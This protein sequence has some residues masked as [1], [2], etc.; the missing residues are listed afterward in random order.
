MLDPVEMLLD[1]NNH[2]DIVLYNDKDEPI[3]F[4]QIAI[5]P[6]RGRIYAILQPV[7]PLDEESEDAAYA[8]EIIKD[9][10]NGDH[11]NLVEDDDLIDEIFKEYKDLYNQ[12]KGG[13]R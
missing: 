4:E 9:K 12:N 3:A 1:P 6:L 13:R 5:I 10:A 11:L 7:V 8:F 2:E